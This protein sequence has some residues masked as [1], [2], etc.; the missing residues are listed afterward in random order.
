MNC[1]LI[2]LGIGSFDALCK[3][4]ILIINQLLKLRQ[5]KACSKTWSGLISSH[6]AGL[7]LLVWFGLYRLFNGLVS[8][9]LLF[10]HCFF[11]NHYKINHDVIYWCCQFFNSHSNDLYQYFLYSIYDL[12]CIY[13]YNCINYWILV[14]TAHD[15]IYHPTHLHI[16]VLFWLWIIIS[17]IKYGQVIRSRG[18][19]N[20]N[21]C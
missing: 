13:L 14:V 16:Y 7:I 10:F 6:L 15:M 12:I 1:K 11:F 8:F 19:V 3:W 20:V 4:T 21:I 17:V 2:P 18:G 5:E 9:F